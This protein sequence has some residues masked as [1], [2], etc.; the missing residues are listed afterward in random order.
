LSRRKRRIGGKAI[1][2][3]NCYQKIEILA[4]SITIKTKDNSHTLEELRKKLIN[5]MYEKSIYTNED[6]EIIKIL[7]N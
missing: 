6:I 3:E 1:K 4:D 5:D 2:F 7:F